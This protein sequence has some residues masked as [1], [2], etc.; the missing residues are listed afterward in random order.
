VLPIAVHK[1][2]NSETATRRVEAALAR[3]GLNRLVGSPVTVVAERCT[4]S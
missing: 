1:R 4:S 2:M 3:V